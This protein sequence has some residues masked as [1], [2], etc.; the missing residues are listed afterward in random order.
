MYNYYNML[1]IIIICHNNYKYVENTITQLI[2]INNELCNFIHIMDN[3]STDEDTINYLK[4][5]KYNIF[6]NKTNNGPWIDIQN[7]T[8]IYNL[9]PEK[10]ILTD[11]DLEFN[12]NLPRNFI[13]IMDNL[14][15]KYNCK[16]LGF[17]LNILDVDN[18][19]NG[20]YA[21][22]KNISD[23]EKRFWE[24]NINDSKYELYNA[25]IDT[26]FCL[27]NKK[28]DNISFNIRIAGDF[29]C[30]HLPWYINDGILNTYEKY[31]LYKNKNISSISRLV[32]PY[33]ES[34]YLKINKNKELFFIE[35]NKNDIN[36]NFWQN[37][38]P[39]WEN[40]TFNIFDRF[41]QKDK[42]FIDIGGWIG[43]TCIY[44]SRKSKHVY[45]V[46]A[47]YM[48]C[49]DLSNN[50][51]INCDN[52]TIISNAIFNE[53][54]KTMLF[55]VNKFLNNS[56]NNDSTSQLYNLDISNISEKTYIVNT[57]TL[58]D[59]IHNYCIDISKI[60]LIKVDIE[61]GEEYILNDLYDIHIKNNTPLYISFHYLWWNDKNLNRFTF[62]SE[63]QKN[64]I[65][66]FPFISL[67]FC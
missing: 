42:I 54:N 38:F 22:D 34:N 50:C 11:P 56:V 32:I 58:K 8:Y 35:N 16:K 67:L 64:N 43:T 20:V 30:K 9:L 29:T 55:G 41:L 60:S 40:E 17:A 65:I 2:K 45:V 4:I 26:T 31:K 19:H 59:I 24:S 1:P 47:D 25:A 13:D 66:Q 6:Y 27:Y 39:Q 49:I 46:E 3:N 63:Q 15:D 12:N 51:K 57:I 5:Q 33:I 44:S 23:Y 28:C 36:L 61:G 21:Y 37:I 18:M 10:F 14:M 48:S 7:N 53:S 52:V 62:L